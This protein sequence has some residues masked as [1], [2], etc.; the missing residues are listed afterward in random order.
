MGVQGLQEWI[1]GLGPLSDR[2]VLV[3]RSSLLKVVARDLSAGTARVRQHDGTELSVN[4]DLACRDFF[5]IEEGSYLKPRYRPLSAL[6][7]GR[8]M[9]VT[10]GGGVVDLVVG[11]VVLLDGTTVVDVLAHADYL[12]DFDA[13]R[14]DA[15][16]SA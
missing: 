1:D 3:Q 13:V 9:T 6:V 16:S 4:W 5:P 8:P 10:H 7:V 2:T 14:K 11:S 12:R 15:L